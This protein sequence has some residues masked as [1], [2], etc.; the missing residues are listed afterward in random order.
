MNHPEN[1]FKLKISTYK[2]IHD[3]YNLY[4]KKITILCFQTK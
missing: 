1:K 3:N 2:Y 4:L